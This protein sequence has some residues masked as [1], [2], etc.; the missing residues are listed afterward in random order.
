MRLKTSSRILLLSTP[1]AGAFCSGADLAERRSMSPSQVAD[2]LDSL[3]AM[4]GELE[5]LRIPTIAAIDGFA[6]GGG[7]EL[8]MGC[9]LRTAGEP[10]LPPSLRVPPMGLAPNPSPVC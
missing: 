5:Q 1:H 7:I 9:D 10:S 3:R 6:L 2:F 8:A 4:I